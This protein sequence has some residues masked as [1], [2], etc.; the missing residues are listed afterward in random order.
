MQTSRKHEQGFIL[1]SSLVIMSLLLVLSVGLWYRSAINQQIS[2]QGQ[3][4]TRAF[5]YAES[6]IHFVDW[7][8][9]NDADLDGELPANDPGDAADH[10]DWLAVARMNRALPGPTTLGGSDG[11][12]AYFDNRPTADRNGF[13]FDASDPTAL[14]PDLS[15]MISSG[16]M[17]AHLVLNIDTSGNI[18]LP[19]PAYSTS[20]VPTNGAV[21][22]LTAVASDSAILE[23]AIIGDDVQLDTDAGTCT[24]TASPVACIEDSVGRKQVE[25]YSIAAYAV[26]YVDGTPMRFL[27][28]LIGTID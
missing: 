2:N 13:V 15:T 8:L 20:S 22:W 21:V 18:T 19:S 23:S 6:A 24:S 3:K 1:L 5:Y 14:N 4:T 12:L 11:Q 25:N 26:A 9:D 17:P 7:A 16:Q 27:R 28:A 10:G